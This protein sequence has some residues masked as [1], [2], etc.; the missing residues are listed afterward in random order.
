MSLA[1]QTLA[2]KDAGS[3]TTQDED[4]SPA[5]VSSSSLGDELHKHVVQCRPMDAS[6]ATC[7][8]QAL[9]EHAG[10]TMAKQLLSN[11]QSRTVRDTDGT[12]KWVLRT[13][14]GHLKL[15]EVVRP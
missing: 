5:D 7:V 10:H 6:K 3:V 1:V 14:C 9:R 15:R 11:A 12:S 2:D 13:D 8:R 4:E